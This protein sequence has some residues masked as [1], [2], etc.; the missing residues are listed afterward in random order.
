MIDK[1]NFLIEVSGRP[2]DDSAVERISRIIHRILLKADPEVRLATVN[3]ARLFYK[4]SWSGFPGDMYYLTLAHKR[5]L[6][7]AGNYFER[8]E[9]TVKICIIDREKEI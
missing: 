8:W 6:K 4:L 7:E 9:Y 1:S 2:I 3:F 5:I